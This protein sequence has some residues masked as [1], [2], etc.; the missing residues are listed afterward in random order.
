MIPELSYPFLEKL[1]LLAKENY[2]RVK[3]LKSRNT[4][5]ALNLKKAKM[6]WYDF[7]G[8]SA[9]Y[10]PN[11]SAQLTNTSLTGVQVGLFVSVGNLLAKG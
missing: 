4:I 7:L 3:A 1:I 8:V 11:T 2:P 9:F 5:A 6:S 10:S